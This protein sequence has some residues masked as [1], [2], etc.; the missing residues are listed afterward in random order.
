MINRNRF[1]VVGVVLAFLNMLAISKAEPGRASEL[2]LCES[3]RV[4]GCV[5]PA[6]TY[7][8]AARDLGGKSVYRFSSDRLTLHAII[9]AVGS[10]SLIRFPM[11]A[12]PY[13]TNSSYRKSMTGHEFLYFDQQATTLEREQPLSFSPYQALISTS[14]AGRSALLR[15]RRAF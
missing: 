13:T 10:N 3:S 5:L 12:L 14:R 11:I 6:V 2:T 15:I 7:E 1:R 4:I 8:T 9:G